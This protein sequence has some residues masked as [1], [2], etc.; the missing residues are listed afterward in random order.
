MEGRSHGEGRRGLF[1]YTSGGTEEEMGAKKGLEVGSW[2]MEE[3]P[4]SLLSQVVF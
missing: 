4:T 2:S 3:L 1:G